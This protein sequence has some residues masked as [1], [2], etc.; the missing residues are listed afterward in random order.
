MQWRRYILTTNN[1]FK[2]LNKTLKAIRE[3]RKQSKSTDL[4]QVGNL[5]LSNNI[6]TP[7]FDHALTT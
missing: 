4:Q 7:S 6:I 5:D 3:T 2:V 1:D